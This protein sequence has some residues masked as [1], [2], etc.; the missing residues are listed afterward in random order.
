[1]SVSLRRYW[2]AETGIFLGVW[3]VLMV[4]GR[5]RL[6]TDPG[7]FWHTVTGR[8]I[9]STGRFLDTDPYSFTFGGR[10]WVPY[11]W[12]AECTMAAVHDGIGGLDSLLLLTVTA[13]A[14]LYTWAAHRLLRAGLHWLPTTLL[15]VLTIAVGA[16]HFLVRPHI[17]TLVFLGMTFAWLCD[18]DA[19]RIG[20][21]RLFWL[22]PL[23]VIWSNWHGGVLGGLGTLGL[24]AAGWFLHAVLRK[25]SPVVGA[26]QA[27]ELGVLVLACLLTVLV[28]PYGLALPRTW[29]Q[30]MGSPVLPRIISEHTPSDPASLP[31]LMVAVLGAGYGLTLA[32]TWPRWPRVTWLIPL[33]WAVLALERVRHASLFGIV[34]VLALAEV[35]PYSRLAHWLARPGRELFR[36]RDSSR[37]DESRLSWRAMVLPATIVATAVLLQ[38]AGV[39]MPILGRGWAKLDPAIWPVEMLTD[40]RRAERGSSGC[41]RVFNDYRFGGFLI[42]YTPRLK[43]F[44][45]DRCEVYGDRWLLDFV[46]AQDH[47][48][49]WVESWAG[50]YGIDYALVHTGA[51]F[52]RYLEKAPGWALVRRVEA[53]TLYRRVGSQEAE[54]DA[55]MGEV[56]D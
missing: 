56:R 21:S 44:V 52:D 14:A 6:L 31:F 51:G 35:L 24:T 19:G 54:G 28:N 5:T 36:F 7:T 48:P 27:L 30:I 37:E 39:P 41:A 53:A 11:E 38:M 3:L 12:L 2:R 45:D 34:A 32:S 4:A 29:L 47:H 42:Y 55:P 15:V 50:R 1:V 26:L 20:L 8:T 25:E 13:L 9:L 17:A 22:I 49:E 16:G 18:V 40:L 46:E 23:F 33:V 43:V 10:P